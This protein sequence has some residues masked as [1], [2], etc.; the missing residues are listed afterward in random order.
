MTVPASPYVRAISVSG[1]TRFSGD[2]WWEAIHYFLHGCW[3]EDPRIF[4]HASLIFDGVVYLFRHHDYY[5]VVMEG[6]AL[7]VLPPV[8]RAE[9]VYHVSSATHETDLGLIMFALNRRRG[10]LVINFPHDRK[11]YLW[12]T[13]KI[14]EL[15]LALEGFE[16]PV[17]LVDLDC[18]ED[19]YDASV[20]DVG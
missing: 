20:D 7:A 3:S 10:M 16:R 12:R 4:G 14:G 19:D 9:N 18:D 1:Q 5:Q 2:Q 6:E 8:Y 13:R 17:E 15:G 11:L